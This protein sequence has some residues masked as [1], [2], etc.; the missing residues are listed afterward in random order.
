MKKQFLSLLLVLLCAFQSYSQDTLKEV[1][2]IGYKNALQKSYNMFYCVGIIIFKGHHPPG[3]G[4][5]GFTRFFDVL[6]QF[7]QTFFAEDGQY[8][9]NAKICLFAADL[10][11]VQKPLDIGC[12]RVGCIELRKWGSDQKNR[13]A[14]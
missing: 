13:T 14:H 8:G 10:F 4:R 7:I 3:I 12:S 2:V 1:K 6:E 11:G 5:Q 9:F